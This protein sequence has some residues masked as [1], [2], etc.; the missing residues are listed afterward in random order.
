MKIGEFIT[1]NTS[2]SF[3]FP[4]GRVLSPILFWLYNYD[5]PVKDSYDENFL[6]FADDL[7]K[8]YA[9]DQKNQETANKINENLAKLEEW[10]NYWRL[11]MA[12]EKCSYMFFSKNK[13][14]G[15]NEKLD[16]T[17]IIK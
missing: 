15:F 1:S 16:L 9:I 13:K 12:P 10:L 6:L 8:T 3:G 5:L 4:Q 11:K 14:T 2:I 17:S 7:V